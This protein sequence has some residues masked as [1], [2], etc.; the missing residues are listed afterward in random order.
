MLRNLF[1]LGMIL[2]TESFRKGQHAAREGLP[3]TDN[4]FTEGTAPWTDWRLGWRLAVR[5]GSD[6]DNRRIALPASG[7]SPYSLGQVAARSGMSP[8]SNPFHPG[9]PAHD[10]WRLGWASGRAA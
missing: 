8:A 3:E 1:G 7:A 2:N 5:T 10:E 4:P 6:N 9:H